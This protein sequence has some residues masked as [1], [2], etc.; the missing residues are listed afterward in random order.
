[1]DPEHCCQLEG[2]ISYDL[3]RIPYC[4]YCVML[5]WRGKRSRLCF[6][7][8]D[9]T[10]EPDWLVGAANLLN[11]VLHPPNTVLHLTYFGILSESE[12]E[13]DGFI[14][15]GSGSSIL[16]ESVYGSGSRV[17]DY[18]NLKKKKIPLKFLLLF[19]YPQAYRT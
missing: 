8:V 2:S 17:F 19:T 13:Y 10:S 7:L 16:S 4:R 5:N 11:Q 3:R 15:N 1:M 6:R 14:E 18:Q 9:T 12:Y